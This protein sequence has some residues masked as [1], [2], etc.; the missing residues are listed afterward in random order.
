MANSRGW[1]LLS[2][3]IPQGGDEKRGQ[4][5]R[6]PSTLQHFSL[7]AQS[8]SAILNVI[9][10]LDYTP[11]DQVLAQSKWPTVKDLYEYRWLMLA[12]DCLCNFLPVPFMKLFTKYE[13]NYNLRRKLT[14]LLPK[15]NTEGLRKLTCYK[16]ESLWNSR[17]ISSKSLSYLFD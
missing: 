6:P 10:G 5:P 12:H 17:A 2:C 14:L 9:Y 7:I 13:C 16:A 1:G 4:M 11:S 15:P 8:R 3:Q